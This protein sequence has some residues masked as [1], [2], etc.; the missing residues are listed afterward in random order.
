MKKE[1]SK[2]AV[3]EI[4]KKWS[5]EIKHPCQFLGTRRKEAGQSPTKQWARKIYWP[6]EVLR[7]EFRSH[8]RS[9]KEKLSKPGGENRLAALRRF[10]TKRKKMAKF[11]T[12]F[13]KPPKREIPACSVCAGRVLTIVARHSDSLQPVDEQGRPLHVVR[14]NKEA[15]TKAQWEL[16]LMNFRVIDRTTGKLT[17]P[18][19]KS[20]T[21]PSRNLGKRK[22]KKENCHRG[23]RV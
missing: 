17:V 18:N 12:S 5:S 7:E 23:G 19:D 1:K 4:R 15:F 8:C 10:T 22:T 2:K 11:S 14:K 21:A 9:A 3:K 6:R 16:A 20:F 13:S